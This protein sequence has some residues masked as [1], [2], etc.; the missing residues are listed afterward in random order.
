MVTSGQTL[1]F[2]V[3][4]ATPETASLFRTHGR[5]LGPKG[6][7][8]SEKRGTVLEDFSTYGTRE[9]KGIELKLDSEGKSSKGAIVRVVVGKVHR[10]C[11]PR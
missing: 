8:P 10:K 7:M 2:D 4:L 3:L 1:P 6:L 9:E 11:P 5:V